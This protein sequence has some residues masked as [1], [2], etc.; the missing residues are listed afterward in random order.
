[1]SKQL[2]VG[3]FGFGVV[4]EGIYQV[5]LQTPSLQAAIKRICIKHPDKVRNAPADLF[6]TDYNA[7]LNDD[8]INVVVELIDDADEAYKI[9]TTALRKGKHVISANKKLIAE[10]LQ[11]ILELQ[12]QS[13]AS[14]LYEAAV[15]GS[16][17]IIRNLEEY[18][19]NDLLQSVYGI[20]NGS[21]NYI[22]SR[23]ASD[24]LTY[25]EALLQAQQ[26]GFA[27]SNPYLDVSGRDAVNK[28]SILL[29]H[30][31]GVLAKP[32]KLLYK[33]IDHLQAA[34]I[35]YAK[36]KGY[37]IKLVAQAVKVGANKIAAFVLP[38]FVTTDNQLYN[39][40]N[41]FNGVTL[42]SKLADRQFLYG[43]GAGRFPT[44]SAVI[45]DLSALRYQYRYEYKK[46]NS[47]VEHTL[48]TD[49]FLKVYV[50]FESW[51]DINKWDFE[52]IEALYS[53][54]H[55]QHLIGLIHAEKLAE[56]EWANA[57]N[58]S[59]IACPE[60]IVQKE[61]LVKKSLKKISLQLAGVN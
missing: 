33:G 7:I 37:K 25:Q 27:E 21:T 35:H 54:E 41:E 34:D 30:A 3:L 57:E 17:P 8:A 44:S 4:G 61:A 2:T 45:S 46:L 40:N 12:E 39:V 23:I 24:G 16:V 42:E 5:L 55:R 38:Q 53:T 32:D 48:T 13:N 6:T 52:S 58:V 18:Y 11:E 47:P 36:E 10:H 49:Y 59:V 56:A 43:K 22:L 28:L 1:M 51:A 60:A 29:T 19:D 14:F 31:Y 9:V 50:G 26:L 15:C 20:V